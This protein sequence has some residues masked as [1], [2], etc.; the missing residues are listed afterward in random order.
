[1]LRAHVTS[2]STLRCEVDVTPRIMARIPR[3]VEDRRAHHANGLLPALIMSAISFRLA[4]EHACRWRRSPTG[5]FASI[6]SSMVDPPGQDVFDAEEF[7]L[8]SSRLFNSRHAFPPFAVVLTSGKPLARC[9]DAIDSQRHFSM[10]FGP[11]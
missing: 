7:G 8:R 1:M 3:R 11:G 9:S 2:F 6:P 4:E 10:G 5:L